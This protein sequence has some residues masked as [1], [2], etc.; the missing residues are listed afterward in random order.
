MDN[1]YIDLLRDSSDKH[2][3]DLDLARALAVQENQ[4]FDPNAVSPRG[5]TGLFQIMPKTAGDP[6]YGQDP[7][8]ADVPLTDPS[9]NVD[10]GIGRLKA[11]ID[12]LLAAYDAAGGFM[13]TPA[14]AGGVASDQEAGDRNAGGA[15]GRR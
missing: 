8:P 6:Q 14:A 1:P 11:M 3:V 2:G 4:T 10:F 5:A 13:A 12:N 9:T 7:Y 15:G